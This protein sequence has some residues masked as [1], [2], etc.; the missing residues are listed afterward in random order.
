MANQRLSWRARAQLST[1]SQGAALLMNWAA[2]VNQ[3]PR[4]MRVQGTPPLST[5]AYCESLVRQRGS[6]AA[7]AAL[8]EGRLTVVGLRRETSTLVNQGRGKYDDDLVVLNGVA[9]LHSVRVFPACTEPG[10]QYAHRAKPL[11]A[12]GRV[13]PRYSDVRFKKLEG[14]DVNKDGILD[15]GRLRAGSYLFSEKDGGYMDA[16]AFQSLDAQVAERDTNGDG[17]FNASDSNRIDLKGAGTAMY[18]H[19][20]GAQVT[21]NTWSAGCQTIPDNLF[22]T[23]LASLGRVKTFYYVLIDGD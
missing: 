18:I 6:R 5:Y 9:G 3:R 19:R 21:R 8:R 14:V 22:V 16:R 7:A 10:A 12:G 17:R 20:G 13:D 1:S 23:F 11:A 2:D 4:L 15:A